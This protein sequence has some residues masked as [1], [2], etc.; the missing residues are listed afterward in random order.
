MR[1]TCYVPKEI[2][3]KWIEAFNRAEVEAIANLYAEN[4]INH[5]VTKAPVEGKPAIKEMFAREFSQAKMV[6]I[7]E[8]I[9]A[10]GEW[11]ILE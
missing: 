9:F 8:N 3:E 11:A 5:Q 10:D 1:P 4:A 2:L 7:P 6:C